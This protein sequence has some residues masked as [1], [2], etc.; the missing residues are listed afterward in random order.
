MTKSM[1]GG[2]VWVGDSGNSHGGGLE[3]AQEQRSLIGGKDSKYM[4][5]ELAAGDQGIESLEK[6]G[7]ESQKKGVN[8][9]GGQ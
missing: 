8:N 5:K 3:G 6:L 9:E 7:R 2:A 4:A 1:K